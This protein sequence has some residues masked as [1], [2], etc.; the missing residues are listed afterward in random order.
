MNFDQVIKH[1]R[2]SLKSLPAATVTKFVVPRGAFSDAD[3][4]S[5]RGSLE[6]L[7]G[8]SRVFEL[9]TEDTQSEP[10]RLGGEAP[11][12]YT[13]VIPVRV[14]YDGGGNFDRSALMAE[15]RKD[16]QALIDAIFRSGWANVG[17]LAHLSAEPG[18]ISSFE[19]GDD[20]GRTFEGLISVIIITASYD[21]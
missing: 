18:E 13:D 17:G 16:Q 14:R 1:V 3:S 20:S 19:L 8:H 15:V 2:T 4:L 9:A 6:E 10:V 7:V 11:S 5:G 12:G 21:L